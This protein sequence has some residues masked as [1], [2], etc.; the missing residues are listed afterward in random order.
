VD[1]DESQKQGVVL[2]CRRDVYQGDEYI[3]TSKTRFTA[4]MK[5]ARNI[6]FFIFVDG[7]KLRVWYNRQIKT[8][9]RY[10]QE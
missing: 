7:L 2:Q 1:K 8:P 5:I 4:K 3:E 9:T 10:S 6:P